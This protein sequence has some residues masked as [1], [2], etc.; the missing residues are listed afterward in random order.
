MVFEDVVGVLTPV[1]CAIIKAEMR[2][3]H[4]QSVTAGPAHRDRM[5]MHAAPLAEFPDAGVRYQRKLSRFLTERL[6]HAE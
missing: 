5:R 6:E 2:R 1:R 4:F 3:N